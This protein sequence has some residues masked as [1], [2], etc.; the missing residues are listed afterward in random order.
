VDAFAEHHLDPVGLLAEDH[1]LD[2]LAI[3]RYTYRNL[4]GIH[5]D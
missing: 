1:D 3:R 2:G 4:L 5:S